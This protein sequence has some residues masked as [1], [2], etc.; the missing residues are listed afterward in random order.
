MWHKCEVCS[1]STIRKYSLRIHML[2]HK[3]PEEFT[4]YK[5]TICSHETNR[6]SNLLIHLLKHKGP[7][8]VTMHQCKECTY[9]TRLR[10][11]VLE[12]RDKRKR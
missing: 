11:V 8:E 5:C 7:G 1:Y 9:E 6:K 2:I 10:L 12:S 3:K 4:M